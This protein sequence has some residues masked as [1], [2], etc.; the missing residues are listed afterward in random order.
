MTEATINWRL[1]K[2]LF[3]E[4]HYYDKE[5]NYRPF[6]HTEFDS[7]LAFQRRVLPE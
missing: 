3:T 5:N 1:M 7:F 6:D 4:V 2:H